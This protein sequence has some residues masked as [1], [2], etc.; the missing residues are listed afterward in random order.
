MDSLASGIQHIGIPTNAIEVTRQFYEGLGFK[1]VF[2]TCGKTDEKVAFIRL[3]NLTVEIY[4]NHS[5]VGKA[6]AIDHIALDVA[7]I[8]RAFQAAMASGYKILEDGIQSLPFWDNGVRYFTI[9]GPNGEKIE[10]NQIM[11]GKKC[12]IS[13]LWE[14]Y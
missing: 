4:E 11:R 13:R 1:T 9:L 5:A 12:M 6:G 8:D 10:F 2:R 3:G 7:D 14:S